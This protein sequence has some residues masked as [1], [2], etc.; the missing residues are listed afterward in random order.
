MGGN[1]SPDYGIVQEVT[2]ARQAILHC[3]SQPLDWVK[4]ASAMAFLMGVSN[5]FKIDLSD[6]AAFKRACTIIDVRMHYGDTNEIQP[7]L[8]VSNYHHFEE[9]M[10]KLR[11]QRCADDRDR[12]YAL[13][14]LRPFFTDIMEVDDKMINIEPDY[15]KPAFEVYRKWAIE[16]TG[17]G[18]CNFLL[19]A[20]L[21]QRNVEMTCGDLSF[22]NGGG[23]WKKGFWI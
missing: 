13:L 6:M 22:V 16:L 2:L 7:A 4:F 23:K 1:G 9:Y 8:L 20:G 10:F 15:D 17:S 18:D 5:T 21:W 12:V 19:G 11:H 14:G 3:G